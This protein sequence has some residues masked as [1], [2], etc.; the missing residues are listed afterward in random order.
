MYI[1]LTFIES[2]Q[3]SCRKIPPFLFLT[4]MGW[5]DNMGILNTVNSGF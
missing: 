3:I 1:L 5:T 2:S 4:S